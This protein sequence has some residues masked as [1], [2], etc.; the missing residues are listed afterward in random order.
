MGIKETIEHLY[1]TN[2]NYTN[3]DQVMN[4]TESLKSLSSD[5]YTD[6]KR[7]I[8]ELLQNADDS[9]IEGQSVDV[10]IKLFDD[11]LVLA[12]TGKAFT[13][14]D[15]QGLCSIN[16]GTK[17]S[18]T[19]KTGYKGIGFKSVFG[20]SKEV[21]VFTN[22][23]YF[24]FD[25]NHNFGWR[26][27]WGDNQE[28]WENDNDRD[29]LYPWQIIPIYIDLS[30]N[31]LNPDIQKFLTDGNCNVATII[32]V[33]QQEEI[34]KSITEL[35]LNANMFLFLKK[36]NSI[37]FE[38]DTTM[39]IN[40]DRNESEL[41]LKKD[42]GIVAQWLI[43]TIVL[44]VPVDLKKLLKA[45]V[46]IPK[47]LQETDN[48][49]LTLAIKKSVNGLEVLSRDESLL[50]AYLP[51]EE[52]KYSLPIL[53]N[54]TFITSANRES[55]H[56]DSKWNQWLFKSISMELFKWIAELVKGE[57]SYQAYDLIPSELKLY[58]DLSN[59]YDD[60]IKE[61]IESISF[62]LSKED[63]LLK[64]NEALID[65][66]V[67][68]EK[69]FIGSEIVEKF[70]KNKIGV[71]NKIVDRPFIIN[72]KFNNKLKNIGVENFSWSDIS[73]FFAFKDFKSEHTVE[74]NIQLIE[75]FKNETEI[76]GT[77]ITKEYLK[78]LAFIY[79]HKGN[80]NY[81][82]KVCF[83]KIDD[84][85]WNN[86]NSD[87]DYVNQILYDLVLSNQNIKGWLEQLGVQEKT[88]I[89]YLETV[90]IPNVDTY[91][92]RENY[93]KTI[94]Y[95]YGLYSNQDIK[96]DTLKQL[97][98]LKLLTKENSL[99]PA[100]Q[101]YFSD[102]YN[103][104]LHIE[105]ILS[106]DIF[107]S[108][109]YLALTT[110]KD[111]VKR[112]FI[113]MGV[114]E[115]ISLIKFTG[116]VDR[117]LLIDNGFSSSY[118]THRSNNTYNM[119]MHSYLNI[120]TISFLGQTNN[121]FLKLF[122][123]DVIQNLEYNEIS[124]NVN[125]R[126][127]H[128]GSFEFVE[129]YVKWYI[130]NN[131]CISTTKGI[132]EKSTNVFLNTDSIKEMAGKYLPV[133]DGIDL[134]DN[135]DW[136]SFFQFKTELTLDDYLEILTN[137]MSDAN[138]EKKIKS[139]NK[140]RVQ[141]VHKALLE[142][143]NNWGTEEIEQVKSWATTAYL[144]D[145][146]DNIILCNDLKY[147]ADGDNSIFH[148]THSFIALNEENKSHQNIETFLGYIGVIIL[149]Q[150]NFS[151]D[152]EGE[153]TESGLKYQLE[154][155]F[156]YLEKWI[157]KIDE[158]FDFT[159][160]NEK[161]NILQ[162]NEASKL[163]LVYDGTI[164]KTVQV[165]LKEN[166]LLVATPWSSNKVMLDLPKFLCSYF[167]LQGSEDK[168]EFL[169][170][171]SDLNEVTEY[172][173]SENIELPTIGT[174]QKNGEIFSKEE[175]VTTLGITEKEYDEISDKFYHIPESSIEKREY[176]QSLLPRSKE[177]VLEYLNSLDEY[178]CDNVDSSALTVLS[179]ITKYG[180][181]IYIIPRPSDYGK[182]IIHY[183]SELD[184]LEYA[185]SELWYEDGTSIPRKLTFGKLLRD[186]KINQIP[187]IW[188]EKEKII[189]II[190]NPKNEEVACETILPSSFNMARI[191]ASLANTNGGY[192]II[193]YSEESG[194]VGLNSDFNVMKLTQ[195]AI[196]YSSYFE[197]FVFNEMKINGKTL[198]TIKVEKSNEDILIEDKKY[199]RVG[200]II[201]E[202]LENT[203]KPLIL[204]E[205]KTDWK[206]MKKALDRFQKLGIYSDLNIQF[207]EYEDMDMGDIELD[208][209]VQTY[210]K[211]E[212]SKKH[213]FI[214][215]RDNNKLV[216]KYGKEK[217]NNHENN[218][219]SF[220]I[221]SINDELDAICIEWYYK[222][223]DLKKENNDGKRIFL[224]KEFLSNGNS[225]CGEY[226][227]EKRNTKPLDILDRDKKVYF[228]S[229]NG[230]ENNIALSKN[231]FTNNV[232]NDVE[233][234]DDFDIEYFKLIF[235]VVEE[236]VND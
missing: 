229:D 69:T 28:V 185:D 60:G 106:D 144:T 203:N 191:M 46:N 18:D 149:R 56:T 52:T 17:K 180:Q 228:K 64:T 179:G 226:V 49:E 94:K 168:L 8:Y 165:H 121:D 70:M 34:Q 155:I 92:T 147:Y 88:D 75:Y 98:T 47:K 15:V 65:E 172:F 213:I 167:S 105:A 111:E 142:Q 136:K 206:H 1:Q 116:A 235:D 71:Q 53:V 232:I 152:F 187:I 85:N 42:A 209:M 223:D 174:P 6:A 224:G 62:V 154:N 101:C 90:I 158:E 177:R 211:N 175:A 25:A 54:S 219:Y 95:L 162:I 3:P 127:G 20:Q 39:I 58:D 45:D 4:Q 118:L 110:N 231:D 135:Q 48:I 125:A 134:T 200:S 196:K 63:T 183:P 99:I 143:S 148:N 236:I 130:K 197:N 145:E 140:K 66:T 188:D 212:Q 79:D 151:I 202:E 108:D 233:G 170:R 225:I 12:H 138:N 222:E 27:E 40:I 51:T 159:S 114:Q 173:E 84:T 120:T 37:K 128:Y 207:K 124:A 87:L 93:D 30:N 76:P 201:K 50:Y 78:K 68:S 57:Y 82:N 115:G 199:I 205:G 73:A 80:L 126:W 210:C 153:E 192:L 190:N 230:W 176:I 104:R 55:L 215:D 171:E 161:L 29:F 96:N 41:V 189:D 216:T 31:N 89:S 217:F 13:D 7:F 193:G 132:C 11:V 112:F 146:D 181:D 21:T 163:S 227:T 221:P 119:L 137:F 129:S 10:V 2:T 220:C 36:I 97:S 35:S 164:L 16:N 122:W 43:H 133:F 86:P 103:P 44:S 204:T 72:T 182:V 194:I 100:S 141:L 59:A 9:A 32:K 117:S 156:P 113:F 157:Q 150:D 166:K 131:P 74:K 83:P 160:L 107:L 81:P 208:R 214:F 169:L 198:V 178:N 22:N 218:V 26:E 19:S 38:T 102:T 195:E 77:T 14:R 91:C 123:N 24:K 5:L 23:E 139:E 67:L 109:E 61:A 186:T 184:T 234:F 33:S